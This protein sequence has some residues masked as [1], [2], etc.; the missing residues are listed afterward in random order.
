[1]SEIK[2]EAVLGYFLKV[3]GNGIKIS[4]F[5]GK[6]YNLCVFL[7]LCVFHKLF[8]DPLYVIVG[9]SRKTGSYEFHLYHFILSNF[10]EVWWLYFFQIISNTHVSSKLWLVSIT[11]FLCFLRVVVDSMVPCMLPY[12]Y[13]FHAECWLSVACIETITAIQGN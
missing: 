13:L 8:E 10:R 11:G 4:L 9:E 1:M 7:I 5:W 12:S 3:A 2:Y 6:I